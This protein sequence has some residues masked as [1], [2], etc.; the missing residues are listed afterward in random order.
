MMGEAVHIE[1]SLV[2]W[3]RHW[4]TPSLMGEVIYHR[5]PLVSL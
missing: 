2:L 3:E 4:E 5:E 1:E